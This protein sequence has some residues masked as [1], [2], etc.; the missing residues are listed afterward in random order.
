MFCL[1]FR[2]SPKFAQLYFFDPSA[3][4]RAE[5]RAGIS[6]L[7]ANPRVLRILLRVLENV[8]VSSNSYYARF[9]TAVNVARYLQSKGLPLPEGDLIPLGPAERDPSAHRGTGI[10]LNHDEASQSRQFVV[11]IAFDFKRM[12]V[13]FQSRSLT[14]DMNRP[15]SFPYSHCI[16][17]GC[18]YTFE[19][20]VCKQFQ[21]PTRRMTR[22]TTACFIHKVV[23]LGTRN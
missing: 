23:H 22:C 11:S 17:A 3:T 21:L 2:E 8:I 19:E 16:F 5:G 6:G 1:C 12:F 4:V 10:A 18:R 15:V 7:D 20:E 9:L 14:S 13:C